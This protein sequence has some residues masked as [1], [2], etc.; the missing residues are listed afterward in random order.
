MPD[1]T[2]PTLLPLL[3]L[4]LVLFLMTTWKDFQTLLD[5]GSAEVFPKGQQELSDGR[6]FRIRVPLLVDF[7]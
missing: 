6:G 4:A 3:P 5:V 1:T 2:H 7:C